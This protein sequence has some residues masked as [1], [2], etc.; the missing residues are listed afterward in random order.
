MYY[1]TFLWPDV[2]ALLERHGLRV[3]AKRGLC[4]PPYARAIIVVATKV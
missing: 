1:L 2:R 3:E 4:A